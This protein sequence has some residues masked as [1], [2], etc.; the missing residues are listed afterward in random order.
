MFATR[1]I[2]PALKATLRSQTPLR[3]NKPAAI[4][5]NRFLATA[6]G[7]KIRISDSIKADHRSLEECRDKIIEAQKAGDHDTQKRWQ[8]ELVWELARHSIGEEL[9]V[10]PA[11]ERLLDN[12]KEM[13]EH[14]RGQHRMVR[15]SLCQAIHPWA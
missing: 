1:T 2:T 5:V 6:A 4:T 13:A 10:Y 3:F 11:F 15:S 7:N 14:D 9:V 12:G 8:N